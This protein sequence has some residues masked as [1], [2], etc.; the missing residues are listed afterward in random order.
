LGLTAID[1]LVLPEKLPPNCPH[2]DWEFEQN[3]IHR[4]YK[5]EGDYITLNF[6]DFGLISVKHGADE[7][8]LSERL[9]GNSKRRED[10]LRERKAEHQKERCFF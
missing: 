4:A 2:C 6:D 10:L 9:C 1:D 7:A 3:E 5:T 8:M